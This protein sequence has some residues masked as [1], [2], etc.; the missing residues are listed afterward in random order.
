MATLPSR[1]IG[2]VNYVVRAESRWPAPFRARL[3]RAGTPPIRVSLRN[4][5]RSG[6]MALT[7][8]PVKA[9]SQVTLTLPVG[10]PVTAEVR[11]AFNDRFG[12]RLD[13]QFDNRQLALLFAAGLVNGLL[14]PAGLRFIVLGAC[15]A[16]YLLV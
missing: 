3:E 13:G 14:S 12:C 2:A 6:F 10:Q 11:W 1:L 8:E 15:I 9:G 4:V 16:M 7:A 5:S